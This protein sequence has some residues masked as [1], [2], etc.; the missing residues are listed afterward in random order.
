MTF[1]IGSFVSL[2]Y[3]RHILENL[4]PQ[5]HQRSWQS[6]LRKKKMNVTYASFV[7]SEDLRWPFEHWAF[8]PTHTSCVGA[9]KKH[10][11]YGANYTLNENK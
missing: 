4:L 8:E 7:L 1:P 10:N 11:I 9:P 6:T 5:Y 3:V 2:V